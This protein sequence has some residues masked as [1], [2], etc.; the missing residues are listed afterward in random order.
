ME[1]E[2]KIEN[3][4]KMTVIVILII[5]IFYGLTIIITKNITSL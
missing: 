5:A 1:N 2:Y 3:L 4:I